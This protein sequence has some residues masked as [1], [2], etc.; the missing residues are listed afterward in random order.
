MALRYPI[1]DGYGGDVVGWVEIN[2]LPQ[3][4]EALPSAAIIPAIKHDRA[5]GENKVMSFAIVPRTAVDITPCEELGEVA[6]AE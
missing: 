5:T 6:P 2:R 3:I 4:E 1:E